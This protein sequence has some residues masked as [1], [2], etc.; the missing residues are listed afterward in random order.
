MK[1]NGRTVAV[2]SLATLDVFLTPGKAARIRCDVCGTAADVHRGLMAPHRPGGSRCAGSLTRYLFD[3]DYADW[4]TRF[5]AAMNAQRKRFDLAATSI[6]PRVRH[7]T[8]VSPVRYPSK[9]APLHRRPVHS[10]QTAGHDA[11]QLDALDAVGKIL[12]DYPVP[13]DCV[14]A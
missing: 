2:S 10:S 8:R 3:I 12:P 4:S 9:P 1:S 5:C 13:T 14:T 11:A 6:D 7:A